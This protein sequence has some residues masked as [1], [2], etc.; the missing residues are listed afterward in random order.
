M[1]PILLLS[2][3]GIA[4]GAIGV[5]AVLCATGAASAPDGAPVPPPSGPR[6]ARLSTASVAAGVSTGFVVLLLTRWPV[7][8][9]LGVVAGAAMPRLVGRTEG[10]ASLQRIEAIAVWTELLRDTLG[11]ASGLSQA[12]VAT[13]ELAPRSLRGCI[14]ALA[15]R[16]SNGVPIEDGLRLLAAEVADPSMDVVACALILAA[17]SQAQR[18]GEVLSALA[19][20]TR[21]EVAM[22]LRVEASRASSRSSVRTVVV[23]S[24]GFAGLLLV[25]ARGYLEPFSSTVGQMVLL[26]VGALYAMGLWLMVRMVRTRPGPRLLMTEV[27]A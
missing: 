25:L 9:V 2:T 14:A 5:I 3:A 23:F 27:N 18:L 17:S 16:L 4:V 15:E 22:R 1:M 10:Q 13:A 19:T 11:A 20:T 8:A 6:A 21:E 26:G 7:A 12:I 24:L